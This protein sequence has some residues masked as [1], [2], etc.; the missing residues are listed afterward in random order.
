MEGTLSSQ[1]SSAH[2]AFMHVAF[3]SL[4]K[5]Y[6]NVLWIFWGVSVKKCLGLTAERASMHGCKKLTEVTAEIG[7]WQGQADQA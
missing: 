3:S 2:K 5:P 7:G 4:S 1:G 6:L